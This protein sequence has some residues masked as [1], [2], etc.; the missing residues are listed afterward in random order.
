MVSAEATQA[1]SDLLQVPLPHVPDGLI[2]A[3]QD[4]AALRYTR[5]LQGKYFIGKA[6][7]F[8]FNLVVAIFFDGLNLATEI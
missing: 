5:S 8:E 3:T 4:L 6:V 1:F 7:L 2:V